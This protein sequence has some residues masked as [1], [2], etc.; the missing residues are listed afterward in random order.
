MPINWKIHAQELKKEKK[1]ILEQLEELKQCYEKFK[2]EFETILNKDYMK[3][4]K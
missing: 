3:Y 2:K 4:R 1:Y